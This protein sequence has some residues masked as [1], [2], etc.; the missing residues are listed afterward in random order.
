MAK[1][2]WCTGEANDKVQI[3]YSN[4]IA[5]VVLLAETLTSDHE[6]IKIQVVKDSVT[7]TYDLNLDNTYEVFPVNMS[8]GS[9]KVRVLENVGGDNYALLFEV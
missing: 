4:S 8:D 3:D 5:R 2:R 1:C 7:Y 6:R 9:Y